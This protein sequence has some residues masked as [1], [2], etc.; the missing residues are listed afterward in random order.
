MIGSETV[1]VKGAFLV[2]TVNGTGYVLAYGINNKT[3]T[4][5]GSFISPVNGMIWAM[6]YDE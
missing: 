4:L 1:Q 2:N 5:D 3:V 6:R